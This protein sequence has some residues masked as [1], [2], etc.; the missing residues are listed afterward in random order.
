MLHLFRWKRLAKATQTYFPDIFSIKVERRKPAAFVESIVGSTAGGLDDEAEGLQGCLA[1]VRPMIAISQ[2]MRKN[3]LDI[4]AVLGA[5]CFELIAYASKHVNEF[6]ECVG[7]TDSPEKKRIAS[8]IYNLNIAIIGCLAADPP[9][10]FAEAYRMCR[11]ELGEGALR[12]RCDGCDRTASEARCPGGKLKQCGRCKV[13]IYCS[14]DCSRKDWKAR[15][16][17]LCFRAAA[18]N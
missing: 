1:L 5:D 15:H 9:Q 14:K 12:D 11:D 3:V 6:L 8:R 17:A 2:L 18:A 7:S 13:A 4:L 10:Q 16:K